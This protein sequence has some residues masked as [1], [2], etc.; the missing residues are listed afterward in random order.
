MSRYPEVT[1]GNEPPVRPTKSSYRHFNVVVYTKSILLHLIYLMSIWD[2]PSKFRTKFTTHLRT[3]LNPMSPISDKFTVYR[4][5]YRV[6]FNRVTD[7]NF[8]IQSLSLLTILGIHLFFTL[9]DVWSS[10]TFSCWCLYDHWVTFYTLVNIDIIQLKY[11]VYSSFMLLCN[12]TSSLSS[13]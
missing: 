11:Y 2:Y 4:K 6:T 1:T 10:K 12:P 3:H 9:V 5:C 7:L 13:N 8:I